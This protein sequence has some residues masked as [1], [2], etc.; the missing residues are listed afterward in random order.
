MA[1]GK[2][3]DHKA[4]TA[5][6]GMPDRDVARPSKVISTSISNQIANLKLGESWAQVKKVHGAMS[7]AAFTAQANEIKE[8]MRQALSSKLS[9]ASQRTGNKY[10]VEV[11]HMISSAC[12]IFVV[13]V[14]TCVSVGTIGLIDDGESVGRNEVEG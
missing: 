13:L 8:S 11:G 10:K 12:N 14:V 5:A 6:L 9:H 3:I 7:V 4:L 2:R 1:T